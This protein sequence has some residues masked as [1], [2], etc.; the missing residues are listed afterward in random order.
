MK[1]KP[2]VS[3]VPGV[4]SRQPT[5]KLKDDITQGDIIG[6]ITPELR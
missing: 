6:D 2:P 5:L 3:F 4:V 1:G